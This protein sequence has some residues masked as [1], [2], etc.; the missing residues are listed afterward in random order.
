M[1]I[2][3]SLENLNVSEECFDEIMGLVEEV[4]NEVSKELHVKAAE[5]SLPKR[6]RAFCLAA[7]KYNAVGGDKTAKEVKD[8]KSRLD[9]AHEIIAQEQPKKV[10]T[11][12]SEVC[13]DEIMGLVEDLIGVT[14]KNLKDAEKKYNKY[15]DR[16]K[17][18]LKAKKENRTLD[19]T[20]RDKAW[21]MVYTGKQAHKFIKAQDLADKAEKLHRETHNY[22]DG[23]Y[24]ERKHKDK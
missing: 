24:Y 7:A 17:K 5:N 14:Q 12:A 9:H 18:V 23:Y 20:V 21:G 1:D 10:T 3:E 19:D 15:T 6:N 16:I 22:P 11:E 2:F 8:T 13:F 4:I